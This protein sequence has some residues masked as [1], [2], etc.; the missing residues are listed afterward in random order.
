MHSVD[1]LH[2]KISGCFN[3]CGQH[4]VA[5]LGFLRRQPQ[6]GGICR[7]AFPG[8]S[9][10]RMGKQRE[11]PTASLS[12]PSHRSTCPAVVARLT[13]RYASNRQ[14]G[15]RLQ[16]FHRA[17]RQDGTQ[18]YSGRFDAFARRSVGPF[19]LQGLGRSLGNIAWATWEVGE[20][21]GEVVSAAEFDL[22]A[23][24]RELFEAQVAWERPEKREAG[25][26]AYQAML[27]AA[28]G[29]VKIDYP[30][31]SDDPE[32]IVARISD[33]I[34]RHAEVLR[35]FCRRQ[36]RSLPVRRPREVASSPSRRTRSRYLIDEA[37][38]FIEAAHS[39][40]NRLGTPG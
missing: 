22:A 30:I 23:A 4:H 40:Y 1:N 34:L 31:I 24:E 38:L 7:T 16:E 17:H 39:C 21:S 26:G 18:K 8:G 32:R 15:E 33:E 11:P 5:D 3:S 25:R 36:I 29:L 6:D 14:D 28:K 12:W 20:C 37:N 13:E 27:R 19:H 9:G 35:S 10:R 2:I